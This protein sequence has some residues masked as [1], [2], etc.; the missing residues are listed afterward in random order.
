MLIGRCAWHR[1]YHGYPLLHG[2]TSWRGLSLRFTDGICPRCLEQFR[3][4][5]RSF[6]ERRHPGPAVSG[7]E[8]PAGAG[9]TSN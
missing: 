7:V 3:S 1:Q 9:G 6:L 4:E 8:A 5:H 2:V